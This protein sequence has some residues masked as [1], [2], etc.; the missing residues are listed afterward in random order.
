MTEQTRT[1]DPAQVQ[2]RSYQTRATADPSKREI[3]GIGVP[4][5]EETQIWP[6]FREVFD[7]ECVFDGIERAK[8]K[9][10]HRDLIGVVAEHQREAG[11]LNIVGRVSA[12]AAGDDALTLAVDGALDSFS[13]GFRSVEYVR[14]DHEDGSFTIR[15]TRVRTSEFSLTDNPAYDG[16]AVTDIRTATTP[17]GVPPM[18]DTIT[19]DDFTG[20][21]S[22]LSEQMREMQT[23]FAQFSDNHRAAPVPAILT[24]SAGEALR[25][26][27][28]GDETAIREYNEIM[29]RA[30]AG[31]TAADSPVKDGWVGDLT[32][33]FDASS[34]VLSQF[35]SEGALPDTGM[36]IEYAQLKANTVKVEEQAAEGNDLATGKVTLETKTAP[37]KTYGGYIELS[38]QQVLRSTLPI[39]N[40]SLEALTVAAGAR[41]KA[42]L[43]AAYL[44]LVAQRTALAANAGVLPIAATLAASTA[45]QWTALIVDAAVKFDSIDYQLEALIVS[46]S[47][48]KRLDALETAGHKVFKVSDDRNTVGHLDLTGL[49]GDI[50]G[51][52]VLADPGRTGD[53]AEFANSE[54]VRQYDSALVQLQDENIINLSKSFSA[55]RFGAVAPE[56]PHAVWPVKFGA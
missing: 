2:T 20:L 53:A 13:I 9:L 27:A 32:K 52:T 41:K 10:Q 26:I 44:A 56:V 36:N 48:F 8:L 18:T 7:Q 21:R 4:L 47:V 43:R 49:T 23:A 16:A 42:V 28:E 33:I 1:F 40:R 45:Q 6:G 37:V 15:H 5:E 17:E 19:A 29:E 54:A 25:A 3:A 50:S 31:G 46:P 39:L 34:G 12:V 24:R 55:Y 22:E 35:F 38:R 11:R 14:T 30:Y 51:V